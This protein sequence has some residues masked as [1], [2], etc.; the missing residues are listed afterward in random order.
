MS[1]FIPIVLAGLLAIAGFGMGQT[2]SGCDG[3]CDDG[4]DGRDEGNHTSSPTSQSPSPSSTGPTAD[5]DDD[6][7]DDDQDCDGERVE[8]EPAKRGDDCEEDSQDQK[9]VEDLRWISFDIDDDLGSIEE[10]RVGDVLILDE[11]RV[12]FGNGSAQLERTGRVIR[13]ADNDTELSIYDDPSGLIRFKA[14]DGSARLDFPAGASIERD[15]HG[16][17]IQY[18]AGRSALLLSGNT[19]WIAPDVAR[20]DGF[21]TLHILPAE[22]AG[23]AAAKPEYREAVEDRRVGA[24]INLKAPSAAATA[25]SDDDSIEVKAYDDVEV[26]VEFSNLRKTPDIPIRIVVSSELKEGRTIVLHLDPTLVGSSDPKNLLLRYYD[27]YP[28]TDGSVVDTEV[29]FREASDLEDVLDA[30]DDNGQP[31]YWVVRDANGL[32]ILIS[33]ARWSPHAITVASLADS[34]VQPSVIVG[35]VIGAGGSVLAAALLFWPRRRDE[36]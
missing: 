18:P 19:T 16:A 27:L 20:M 4:D 29:V 17:R 35:I 12:D 30:T 23:P 14:G 32:Q 1:R 28:Q 7:K 34:L 26:D 10:F 5:P 36:E 3:D 6:E 9:D 8:D 15:I 11:L 33:V 24:E 25:A 31:E 13:L 21:F 2:S 22:T